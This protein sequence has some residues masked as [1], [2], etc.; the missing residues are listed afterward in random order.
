[1]SDF[2]FNTVGFPCIT[3]LLLNLQVIFRRF[4]RYS[5]P[6][7]GNDLLGLFPFHNFFLSIKSKHTDKLYE[8]K[9]I[10]RFSLKKSIKL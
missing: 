2:P 5:T 6:Q 8:F 10:Y 9:Q 1:M 3:N 7:G 4:A